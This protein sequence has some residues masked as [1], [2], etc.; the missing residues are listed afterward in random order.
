MQILKSVSMLLDHIRAVEEDTINLSR[1]SLLKLSTYLEKNNMV[2]DDDVAEALQYQ[3]IISQQLS[4][5]IEAIDE[6]QKSL[7]VF[8]HAYANDENIAIVSMEK[9]QGK[10]GRALTKAQEKRD[11]FSGKIHQA[12]DADDEI[13]FF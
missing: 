11:A 2:I 3:D 8:D 4:A 7:T 1:E 9:L 6:V 5:T 12:A 10:L 13:E